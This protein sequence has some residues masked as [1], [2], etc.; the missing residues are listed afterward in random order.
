MSRHDI[1][2]IMA[3]YAQA[4]TKQAQ[5]GRRT[6]PVSPGRVGADTKPGEFAV[7]Q[8][9]VP[10]SENPWAQWGFGLGGAGV[11]RFLG[12]QAQRVG[13]NRALGRNW[14]S[15]APIREAFTDQPQVAAA[16]PAE[17]A[18]GIPG[19]PTGR[20]LLSNL[21]A[22]A[23]NSA[24]NTGRAPS[25]ISASK[26][27]SLVPVLPPDSI[28][29]PP[30]PSPDGPIPIADDQTAWMYGRDEP[31]RPQP[32]SLAALAGEG[33]AAPI[34]AATPSARGPAGRVAA[35]RLMG[36]P[37]A[38]SSV[39][40]ESKNQRG[41]V[42][43]EDLVQEKV[44]DAAERF[45]RDMRNPDVSRIA[46]TTPGGAGVFRPDDP[47]GGTLLN[48]RGINRAIPRG[49]VGRLLNL[50]ID[51]GIPAVGFGAGYSL[52]GEATQDSRNVIRR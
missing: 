44:P 42:I 29:L 8:E 1:S 24:V 47:A 7:T 2:D 39:S 51:I 28:P 40:L 22:R 37:D 46:V 36:N 4:R 32:G 9:A 27:P 41:G 30:L 26:A 49:R 3:K 10:G 15:P 12:Q 17:T 5:E 52:G 48:P 18:G 45:V 25:V 6:I 13:T 16:S 50:G 35:L 43:G 38:D 23:T 21:I 31:G 33:A 11:G 19:S 34:P 14:F 20:S